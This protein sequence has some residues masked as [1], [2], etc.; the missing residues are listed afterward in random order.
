[1]SS[2]GVSMGEHDV[3]KTVL[4][5]L[6]GVNFW[7]IAMKPAK[8][9]AFAML[10][11]SPLFGLPGNPVSAVVAFEQ[12]VRPMLLRRMGA[13]RLFRPR[14][15]GILTET[16]HTNS[17]K[18]TFLRVATQYEGGVWLVRQSGGQDSN[19]MSAMARADAFAIIPVGV[20]TLEAGSAVDLE[21]FRWPELR[22]AENA[23][24]S[25]D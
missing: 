7:Q 1:M 20:G 5:Q 16:I 17:S 13:T 9:L 25:F 24:G 2:G 12:F 23:L 6:G 11:G 4:R 10:D 19:V 15:G 21:M 8:P 14:I 18:A 3:V 22:T